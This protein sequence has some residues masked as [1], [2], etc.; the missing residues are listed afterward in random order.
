[1]PTEM[2]ID[3]LVPKK[4]KSFNVTVEPLSNGVDLSKFGPKSASKNL[5]K[6]SFAKG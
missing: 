4:R 1:M 2:A 5:S 6:I 3:D